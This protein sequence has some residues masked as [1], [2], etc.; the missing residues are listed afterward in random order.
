[1]VPRM[2][3]ELDQNGLVQ[4]LQQPGVVVDL[5]TSLCKQEGFDGL[6]SRQ[7]FVSVCII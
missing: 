2:L 4:L 6:V 7:A 1:M 3:F 5:L